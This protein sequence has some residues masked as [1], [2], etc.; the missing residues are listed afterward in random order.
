MRTLHEYYEKLPENFLFHE[1]NK[2]KLRRVHSKD[3]K[4]DI[5]KLAHFLGSR[6]VKK[7]TYVAVVVPSSI[8]WIIIDGAI[9]TLGAISVPMF[10]TTSEENLRY[11][12]NQTRASVLFFTDEV[13][14]K[15]LKGVDFRIRIGVKQK[16]TLPAGVLDFSTILQSEQEERALSQNFLSPSLTPDDVFTVIYTSGSTGKPKGVE[17]THKNILSQIAA[18]SRSFKLTREDCALSFLPFAHSFERMVMYFYMKH[19]V[20]IYILDD[21]KYLKG[22]LKSARPT[23]M[24]LVPR[25]LEKIYKGLRQK[26]KK[27][28]GLK[29]KIFKLAMSAAMHDRPHPFTFFFKKLVYEKILK[30]LG[31]HFRFLIS[32]GAPL[33]PRL[34]TFF[35][36]LGFPLYQGYGLTETSPVVST[37]TPTDHEPHTCGKPIHDVR[38][39]ISKEG[40]VLVKGP[41]VFKGYYRSKARTKKMID[42]KGWLHT[43]DKGILTEK[44]YLIIN[45]RLK[46]H[47][48]L[49]TGKFMNPHLLEQKILEN[50]LADHAMVI[51]ENRPFVTCLLF[52]KEKKKKEEMEKV[53]ERVNKNFNAWERIRRFEIINKDLTIEEGTMTP[54]FKIRRHVIQK[55]YAKEIKR[56]YR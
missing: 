54:S 17:L 35:R 13:I 44:G 24:T 10:P 20:N 27:L 32:G 52:C 55:K 38:V 42:A 23:V 36:R 22:A 26:E 40:E 5:L 39:K 29:Q 25:V 15:K 50:G 8:D 2:K 45:G 49:S 28:R 37:N 19:G 4:M 51:G 21:V 14:L 48:K 46:D 7:G 34:E 9:Q 18:V 31:G 33:S 1:F 43:G 53:I 56:L 16:K 30:E 12:I 6:G 47:I 11:Q 41:N 3:L